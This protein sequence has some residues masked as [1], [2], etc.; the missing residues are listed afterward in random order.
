MNRIQFL[1]V[2]C[3]LLCNTL[4]SI[5]SAQ[6]CVSQ[7]GYSIDWWFIRKLPQSK[8][9]LY[10]D[11]YSQKIQYFTDI[12]D[13]NSA[14]G[15]TIS[16]GQ[17]FMAYNDDAWNNDKMLPQ[18]S[19]SNQPYRSINKGLILMNTI[20]ESTSYVHI[21]H[22]LPNFPIYTSSNSYRKVN[23]PNP[24]YP[25]DELQN[26]F[27]HTFL[28]HS[29]T[30]IA[31]ISNVL[32][33]S[34]PFIYSTNYFPPPDF[35]PQQ[36]KDLYNNVQFPVLS[37]TFGGFEIITASTDQWLSLGMIPTAN[38]KSPD[39]GYDIV[40]ETHI[41]PELAKQLNIPEKLQRWRSSVDKS[42]I[43]FNPNSNKVCIGDRNGDPNTPDY[44]SG[45]TI[46]CLESSILSA[47]FKSSAGKVRKT[48]TTTEVNYIKQT[49]FKGPL[50]LPSTN[51][52]PST[53]PSFQYFE[54]LPDKLLKNTQLQFNNYDST[55]VYSAV[56]EANIIQSDVNS[57]VEF[58]KNY[59]PKISVLLKDTTILPD[60]Q[61]N[62]L[63]IVDSN[64]INPKVLSIPVE[65]KDG[66]LEVKSSNDFE[67]N[68]IFL[69]KAIQLYL[70]EMTP[71]SLRVAPELVYVRHPIRV[72]VDL[73]TKTG[74]ISL[75]YIASKI[76]FDLGDG[77]CIENVYRS[78]LH[79]FIHT[80]NYQFTPTA[81]LDY[82]FDEIQTSLTTPLFK[83][84]RNAFSMYFRQL[85][86]KSLPEDTL[87]SL[88]T[89]SISPRNIEYFK[90]P[91]DFDLSKGIYTEG[92]VTSYLWDL[93]DE[94]KDSATDKLYV[95]DYD[96]VL[97]DS[98][99]KT[100][101]QKSPTST[102]P[103][104]IIPFSLD[105]PEKPEFV[106]QLLFYN[107]LIVCPTK[108]T[109]GKGPANPTDLI[110]QFT[111]RGICPNDVQILGDKL[112][113][114][115]T[116]WAGDY[117]NYPLS[118]DWTTNQLFP[119]LYDDP[120]LMV[121][122]QSLESF[123]NIDSRIDTTCDL[124]LE[125]NSPISAK[126]MAII[127][128]ELTDLAL[129]AQK[130]FSFKDL[131]I[132]YS[133]PKKSDL[134][135][136]LGI[137]TYSGLLCNFD[138]MDL[139]KFSSG[140]LYD[141]CPIEPII[142]NIVGLEGPPS[143]NTPITIYGRNLFDVS[144][145]S[146]VNI[147]VGSKNCPIIDK[148]N[149]LVPSDPQRVICQGPKGLG[150][151]PIKIT[152]YVSSKLPSQSEQQEYQFT[153]FAPIVNSIVYPSNEQDKIIN[154][155]GATLT[156]T[157]N[158]FF[159]DP[160]N[161]LLN[162]L[163]KI[164]A[165][166]NE[167]LIA[168]KYFKNGDTDNIEFI[169]KGVGENVVIQLMVSGQILT[170]LNEISSVLELDFDPPTVSSIS[171]SNSPVA[172]G[173]TIFI[174]GNNFG[175][176]PNEKYEI[177]VFIGGVECEEV[178][179]INNNKISAKIPYNVGKDRPV[180]VAVGGQLSGDT[181]TFSYDAPSIDYVVYDHLYTNIDSQ[182]WIIGKNL[183]TK[184][185]YTPEVLLFGDEEYTLDCYADQSVY[186][187]KLY[188]DDDGN[189]TSVPS[190][191][192]P[193]TDFDPYIA[194][195]PVYRVS[196]DFDC[197]FC[198]IPPGIGKDIGFQ[199]IVYNQIVQSQPVLH[200]KKNFIDKVGPTRSPTSGKGILTIEGNNMVPNEWIPIINEDE[201]D[202][203]SSL[204]SGTQYNYVTIDYSP[205][206]KFQCTNINWKE[207][208]LVECEIPPGY[209]KDLPVAVWVGNQRNE[210]YPKVTFSYDRPSVNRENPITRR[211]K[212]GVEETLDIKGENLVPEEL[213]DIILPSNNINVVYGEG[214]N[215]RIRECI[216]IT[217]KN[218]QLA[219]CKIPLGTG[220]NVKIQVTVGGQISESIPYFSYEKP[221]IQEIKPD[222]VRMSEKST[223]T[224]NGDNLGIKDIQPQPI[225]KLTLDQE[226]FYATCKPIEITTQLICDIGPFDK[227]S[228]NYQLTL[229]L[230]GQISDPPTSINIYGKPTIT[231]I[232]P[233]ST[234]EGGITITIKGKN[235]KEE[236]G[237]TT[238][239]VNGEPTTII[240]YSTNEIQFTSVPGGGT[241][242][243]VIVDVNEQIVESNLYSYSAPLINS[244]APPS[245]LTN[246][247]QRIVITG[248]N[249]GLTNK[250][251]KVKVT[252]GNNDCNS[253]DVTSSSE[254]HCLAPIYS[255]PNT[256]PVILKFYDQSQLN[257]Y[258]FEYV[259][260]PTTSPKPTS[261][262][263]GKNLE[264]FLKSAI[265]AVAVAGGLA[266]FAYQTGT[267]GAVTIVTQSPIEFSINNVI[268]APGDLPYNLVFQKLV[269]LNVILTIPVPL[270]RDTDAVEQ[271]TNDP[272]TPL[273]YVDGIVIETSS[274]NYLVEYDTTYEISQYVTFSGT[275]H[276]NDN[277]RESEKVKLDCTFE[278]VIPKVI[279]TSPPPTS[280]TN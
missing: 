257:A 225:V 149:P 47:F 263:G 240:S 190:E 115:V 140:Y 51:P 90:F 172:G 271:R 180:V 35:L 159:D 236:R 31:D 218:D 231:E 49:M 124:K 274:N 238:L 223:I 269:D 227:E 68:L 144:L 3:L 36:V 228:S 210:N 202:P 206:Q 232:S 111:S 89:C 20:Y 116:L 151:Q 196:V 63:D 181:V 137:V 213:K 153:Y 217:W 150:I 78:L 226:I 4:I 79:F 158:N 107:N 157:G 37:G 29:S 194:L 53:S 110:S 214:E 184:S 120:S 14:L 265:P 143:F 235:L 77:F 5:S 61:I 279:P 207:S 165:N 67:R 222:R 259:D 277:S 16:Y 131:S 197:F 57:M 220:A 205:L 270:L 50:Q 189:P 108:Q 21:K 188:Y 25:N 162:Q 100:I 135:K 185:G 221:V 80:L 73:A 118:M 195:D 264:L 23:D 113:E 182:F 168:T 95:G 112:S 39:S 33:G 154:P 209:G 170:E 156:I 211:V 129:M 52:Y 178:T 160:T 127:S 114:Y 96:S 38:M 42:M 54:S 187:N 13:K 272:S 136:G 10:F 245:S 48:G 24:W 125:Q 58:N 66:Y 161:P 128:T 99:M 126:A 43:A 75:I 203:I 32:K 122:Y 8:S 183:G 27:G 266:Y 132:F 11:S 41:P 268:Q 216:Q 230:D 59:Q 121:K 280:N 83:G 60:F 45:E 199:M 133:L 81:P 176:G 84:L 141:L 250:K 278:S 65:I 166:N 139:A 252:I 70:D 276:F 262:P 82:K 224:I 7:D 244:I 247:N 86:F 138:F 201:P 208:T 18:F 253:I 261:R 123:M 234:V 198:L 44:N 242:I 260:S 69:Y 248:T 237:P 94:N 175:P 71:I 64:D 191:Q 55:A 98:V 171:K 22:T 148:L 145:V 215:E 74:S 256:V 249:L 17:Y 163:V 19:Y 155:T 258:T 109:C 174:N 130:S 62:R 192:I 173:E 146:K 104:G 1:L 241:N 193:D 93:I 243:P 169:A 254:V 97:I 255:N 103:N 2:S 91:T 179:W 134:T 246:Q 152:P 219:Q 76:S 186:M 46:I 105:I 40:T 273:G 267:G 101:K 200:Y 72:Q 106:K 275:A 26:S 28:C 239:K 92:W 117:S 204:D 30:R 251:A 233:T 88:D 85:I 229:E 119:V 167:V 34:H 6:K 142:T 147:N 56:Y 164:S 102:I 87:Q 12:S 9:F 212:I 177:T 15:N